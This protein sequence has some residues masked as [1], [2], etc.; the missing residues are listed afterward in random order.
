MPDQSQWTSR[1]FWQA[2]APALHVEDR[3]FILSV[4]EFAID[5]G[6]AA[7]LGERIRHEGYFDLLPN[8]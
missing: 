4:P 7:S 6:R 2:L 5:A 1:A 3:D 8:R